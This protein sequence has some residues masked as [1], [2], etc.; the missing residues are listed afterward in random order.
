MITIQ[1]IELALTKYCGSKNTWDVFDNKILFIIGG[2]YYCLYSPC[3]YGFL[4]D[5][6]PKSECLKLLDICNR[7]K[8]YFFKKHHVEYG[9][10][11]YGINELIEDLRSWI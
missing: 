2:E 10:I 11:D 3:I 9:T 5:P 4:E 6:T 1:E 8:K 7:Q